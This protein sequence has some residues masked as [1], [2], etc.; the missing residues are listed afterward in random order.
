[1]A[2]LLRSE[3]IVNCALCSARGYFEQVGTLNYCSECN[4]KIKSRLQKSQEKSNSISLGYNELLDLKTLR[5]LTPKTLVYLALRFEN[6]R[7][8]LIS[9]DIPSFCHRWGL[10]VE[11]FLSSVSSLSKQ[12]F[13]LWDIAN[14]NIETKFTKDLD[15]SKPPSVSSEQPTRPPLV[16]TVDGI[17]ELNSAGLL[18]DRSYVYLFLKMDIGD[19]NAEINMD[20]LTFRLGF[21]KN[22]LLTHLC[23]LSKR[24]LI[25]VDLQDFTAQSLTVQERLTALENSL[26]K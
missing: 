22:E 24:K 5:I 25:S 3:E 12:G 19:G 11:D 16:F 15:F 10:A 17:R 13:V 21:S 7:H 14:V 9:L 18:S 8:N 1:M 2:S 23:A 20:K 26:G 4:E 6:Y